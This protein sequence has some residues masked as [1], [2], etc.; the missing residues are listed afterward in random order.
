M[1]GCLRMAW[2]Y[3]FGPFGC[4]TYI[5]ILAR[6]FLST[7][8]SACRGGE[9][10]AELMRAARWREPTRV[11]EKTAGGIGSPLA[12]SVAL[13]SPCPLTSKPPPPFPP[14]RAL[15]P[16]RILHRRAGKRL[17]GR[18]WSAPPILLPPLPR[19]V[20]RLLLAPLMVLSSIIAYS[21]YLRYVSMWKE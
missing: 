20:S 8:L 15:C 16:G 7:R 3:G 17:T 21:L 10:S 12:N 18:W 9:R 14:L 2:E 6:S 4:L 1:F 13:F 11:P 19:V 5:Q